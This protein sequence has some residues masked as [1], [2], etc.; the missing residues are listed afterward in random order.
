LLCET[1]GG[2]DHNEH[3]DDQV[4]AESWLERWQ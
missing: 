2:P 3:P 4:T 1:T